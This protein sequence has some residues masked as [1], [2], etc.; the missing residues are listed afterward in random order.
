MQIDIFSSNNIDGKLN[1][2]N[3]GN[4]KAPMDVEAYGISNLYFIFCSNGILPDRL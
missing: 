1:M 4:K 2:K 3:R